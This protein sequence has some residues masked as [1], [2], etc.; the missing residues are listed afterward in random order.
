[1]KYTI[2]SALVASSEAAPQF[3][4]NIVN[5]FAAAPQVEKS[6]TEA[7]INLNGLKGNQ[8]SLTLGSFTDLTITAVENRSTGYS[9]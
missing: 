7:S 2:L 1:M 5:L 4:N 6:H 9:W 3:M 8:G